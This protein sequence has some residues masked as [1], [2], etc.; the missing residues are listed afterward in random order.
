[1]VGVSLTLSL[2]RVLCLRTHMRLNCSNGIPSTPE[3]SANIKRVQN[4]LDGRSILSRS[5]QHAGLIG[6]IDSLWYCHLRICAMLQ[7][8]P[9]VASLMVDTVLMLDDPSEQTEH[10]S[11]VSTLRI[12]TY[13]HVRALVPPGRAGMALTQCPGNGGRALGRDAWKC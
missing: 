7:G 12:D 8:E 6:E 13:P 2:N 3:A 4:V 10:D 5:G 11:K 9:P 1:M